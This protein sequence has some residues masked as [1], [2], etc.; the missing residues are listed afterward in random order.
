MDYLLKERK[1]KS[2][3]RKYNRWIMLAMLFCFLF[4]LSFLTAVIDTT[5]PNVTGPCGFQLLCLPLDSCSNIFRFHWQT[6]LYSLCK[7]LAQM[8]HF[9][10]ICLF[11]HLSDTCF[12][13]CRCYVLQWTPPL[14]S[15]LRH[16]GWRQVG[17]LLFN[18]LY[19]T[20][21]AFKNRSRLCLYIYIRF[22]SHGKRLVN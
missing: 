12:F 13:S 2:R 20:K 15:L 16:V 10:D 22:Y 8:L 4:F 9:T 3:R 7:I 6:K 17:L 11:W 19:V 5:V 1:K 18:G 21:Y 14:I